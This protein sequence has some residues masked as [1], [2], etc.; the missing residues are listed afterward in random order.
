MRVNRS[1]KVGLDIIKLACKG[2]MAHIMIMIM[3]NIII[4]FLLCKSN[5]NL[6][7][8]I[9]QYLKQYSV[10]NNTVGYIINNLFYYMAPYNAVE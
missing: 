8:P 4:Y 5:V 2:S 10:F 7:R 6:C 1:A 3:I 9:F